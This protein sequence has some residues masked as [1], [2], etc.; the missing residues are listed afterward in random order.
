MEWLPDA[1]SLL[2]CSSVSL[3][4]AFIAFPLCLR[5]FEPLCYALVFCHFGGCSRTFRRAMPTA[6]PQ[7][8]LPLLSP[9]VRHNGGCSRIC[10]RFM[11]R[12]IR[13]LAAVPVLPAVHFGDNLGR[14]G[15]NRKFIT[16][17]KPILNKLL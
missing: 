3:G 10:R 2:L 5:V 15:T 11:W 17:Y 13:T 7:R 6:P 1:F 9:N 4:Y 14:I 16:T 8:H 12:K